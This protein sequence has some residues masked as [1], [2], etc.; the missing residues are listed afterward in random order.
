YGATL[1]HRRS[2]AGAR[3][4]GRGRHPGTV[5]RLR[6][7]L[8]E[9]PRQPLF[10]PVLDWTGSGLVGFA[11]QVGQPTACPRLVDRQLAGPVDL[12]VLARRV[13]PAG[14]VGLAD[15]VGPVDL[16]VLVVLVDP[17]EPAGL[18]VPAGFAVLAGPVVLAALVVVLV[19][20]DGP[21][22]P[23]G[24]VGLAEI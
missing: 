3:F 16:V 11:G 17:V 20:P 24:P 13:G 2:S 23:V 4:G 22:R 14:P 1:R 10:Q 18:V 19:C 6:A 9:R 8:R 21:V 15:P 5:V 12:A 7:C